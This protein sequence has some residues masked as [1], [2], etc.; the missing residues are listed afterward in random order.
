MQRRPEPELMNDHAQVVAYAQADFS[1]GDQVLIE[2]L[3]PLLANRGSKL[4]I[5]DLGCG[6]GNITLRLAEQWSDAEVIGIDGS[7][8]ML[9]IARKRA[10]AQGRLTRFL[11]ASIQQL[12]TTP[13]PVALA[14]ADV[15][16]S[17]SVLHH[18]HDPQQFWRL[19]CLLGSPGTV[20]LHRDLRRPESEQ[21]LNAL[22][23]RYLPEAPICLIDD[24]RASLRAAFTVDEVQSQLQLISLEQLVVQEEDDRYLSVMGVL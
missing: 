13:L 20:V 19:V 1:A 15:I 11:K 22:Q 24:Y 12:I 10:E 4:K 17:N 14:S 5:V 18:L 21:Q 6:P 8:A 2:Q 16:V 9:S 7:A 3:E 23:Q